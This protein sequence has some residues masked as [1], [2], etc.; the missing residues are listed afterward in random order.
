MALYIGETKVEFNLGSVQYIVNAS[1][2]APIINTVM[3]LSSDKYI[4]KD[5]NGAY[6]TV[7]DGE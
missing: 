3:L 6:L 1:F 4:L 5:S 2:A 7:K